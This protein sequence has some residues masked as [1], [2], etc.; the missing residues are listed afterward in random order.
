MKKSKTLGQM[1]G[2]IVVT[3]FF[4]PMTVFILINQFQ[5]WQIIYKTRVSDMQ[6]E[7]RTADMTLDLVLDKH[8]TILYDFCTD[9]SNI[10]LVRNIN[11]R[12]DEMSVNAN[13]LR[14]KL[15]HICNRN[16]GVVGI[17]LV[18]RDGKCFFYDWENSSSV[19]STW[20]AQI[21]IPKFTKG[22]VYWGGKVCVKAGD[23]EKHLLHISRKLVDYR[24]IDY[25]I[26]TVVMSIDQK[27][28]WEY[29]TP[30]EDS[31]LYIT[32]GTT[33]IAS[34]DSDMIRK[35]ISMVE[36]RNR[37]IE[38]IVNKKTGWTLYDYYSTKGY[39]KAIASHSQIWGICSIVL[40]LLVN[41]I[42]QNLM[43]PMNSKI[44]DLTTA[45][46]RMEQGDLSVQVKPNPDLPLE[47]SKIVDGFN[48]MVVETK[49]M[50]EKVKQS[51]EEQKNAELSAMEAQID[52]HFLY[53]TLDTIN[54]KALEREE[55]EIS[56]MVG[57]LADILRYSIR[58]PG[59]MVT[60]TNEIYWL[61]QYLVL[62]KE[63]LGQP[64][65]V[66]ID[67][68]ED[69]YGYK[70]HKLMLQPFLE[71][72][73]KH[74]FYQMQTPCI[75][76]IRIRLV[77]NQLHITVR[78]NGRGIAP[79]VLIKLNDKRSELKGHVGVANVRK[80]LELY[81][82]ED[83][84]LYFES[85]GGKGTTVHLFVKAIREKEEDDE[86]SDC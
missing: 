50:V 19:S 70:I 6:N 44:Q 39:Q 33:I 17:T 52:P 2:V 8:T 65:S 64:L 79:D 53:N 84:D 61:E 38:S 75:V 15:S 58:N 5:L 57:A 22:T 11:E 45:M 67:I 13:R 69:L 56:E 47:M 14:R 46:F 43:K 16:E 81:Y 71:N 86:N 1:M 21:Q 51:M 72:S 7:I 59:E 41:Y 48:V 30:N 29:I 62:Q 35:D 54:W 27:E 82:G 9:D 60:V 10:D 20:A 25:E 4:I 42:L 24:N 78:D 37:W 80:R 66:Q 55:Y 23:Q 36:M 83:A 68:P 3:A 63:K 26:G 32:D 34:P 77:E 73:I 28:I 12:Q 76:N 18:T 74:G 85:N 31:D 40:F 49:T